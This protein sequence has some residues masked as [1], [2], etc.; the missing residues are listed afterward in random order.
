MQE[1]NIVY[2]HGGIN[3]WCIPYMKK[4]DRFI[5]VKTGERI[6]KNRIQ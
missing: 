3:M 4:K 5:E 6:K 2:K 1:I